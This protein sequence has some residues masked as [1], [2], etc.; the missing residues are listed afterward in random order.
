MLTLTNV[1]AA[2]GGAYCV[3]VTGACGS[4]SSCA[5][6]TVGTNTAAT[7]LASQVK[8]PGETATFSTVASGTGPFTYVWKKDGIILPGES[9]SS[10]T[11]ASVSAAQAGSYCVEV[12]GHCTSVTNYGDL[13]IRT[14]VTAQ[15]LV[16][17]TNCPG[18]SATF[19]TVAHGDGPYTYQWTR[20]GVPLTGRSDS[21]LVLTGLTAADAGTYAVQVSGACN[22]VTNFATLTINQEAFVASPPVSLTNCPGTSASFS[23]TAG[24]TGPFSYQWLKDGLA[25]PGKTNSSLTLPSVSTADAG[26]YS[27]L[28]TGACGNSVFGDAVLVLNSNVALASQPLSITNCPGTS[29]SFSTL[30]SGTGPFRYQWFKDGN[31]LTGQTNSSLTLASVSAADAGTYSVTVSGACGNA[32]TASATLTVN[33]NVVVSAPPVSLTNCSGSTATFSVSA[34]GTGLSYQWLRGTTTLIGQTNSTLTL[35]AVTAADADTYRVVIFGVCGNPVT[36]SASL[37]VSAATAAD[38]LVSQTVCPGAALGF[39]TSAHGTGPFTY[40]WLKNGVPLAGRTA[41]SL[42][43]SNVAVADAGTYTV[44][45]TGACNGTSQSAVLTVNLQ[46]TADALVPQ[47]VCPGAALSIST[48]AHGTGPFTYKWIKDGKPLPGGTTSSWSVPSATVLDEG[49]YVVIVT[50]TCNAVTNSGV[51]TVHPPTTATP[52]ANQTLCFG[53]TA[54][55]TTIPS[56]TGPFSFVW[57]KDG[58]VLVGR[59][60]GSLTISHLKAA[61]AGTYSVDVSG[62][63]DSVT[64]SATLTV[65]SDGLLS[66]ATFSNP[67]P[68][69][70]ADFSAATPYPSSIEVSCVPGALAQVTVTLSNLSHTYASDIDILLVSPSGQAV[71]LMSDVGTGNPI[72]NA[73]IGFSDASASF[74]PKS[75]LVATGVYKPTDYSPEDNLP[76]PAPLGPYA[77]S[78]AAF[79][80]AD[81]NGTWSLYVVDDALVDT[82]M[83]AGGWSLTLAWESSEPPVP[84]VQ[85]TLMIDGSAQVTLQAQPGKTYVIE[86]STDLVNWAPIQTNTLS[87]STYNLV[88]QQSVNAAQRFYRAVLRP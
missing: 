9:G 19:S 5:M 54:T 84:L 45:V 60:N 16:S 66:P 24:G 55:F 25:L 7:A 83:L 88:D 49:N 43:L 80:G 77:T 52:L 30:A 10:L 36:R 81:A 87:G 51:V 2:D 47:A 75:G 8:C 65:A 20:N 37:T 82:G 78:L 41:N 53:G 27:V 67:T 11:V 13:A 50:G 34:T 23:V 79:N 4:A 28:V 12:T 74:A 15:P 14:P 6:L 3:E 31:P 58:A 38:P 26:A 18:A 17:Q 64:R 40:Q 70:L 44:Q 32:V 39:S 62:L 86:A 33:Q 1:T 76:L 61:D 35:P 48:T 56:G 68:I 85:P 29:A 71:M 21:S 73:T 59:T 72:S 46:T 42:S 57:K 69:A 63:C 22:S